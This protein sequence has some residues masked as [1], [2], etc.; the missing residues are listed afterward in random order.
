MLHLTSIFL[1]VCIRK[2]N[3]KEVKP[4]NLIGPQ[5]KR[6]AEQKKERPRK[7]IPAP[8]KRGKNE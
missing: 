6:R 1:H 5:A 4:L 3:R 8:L 7:N 2:S